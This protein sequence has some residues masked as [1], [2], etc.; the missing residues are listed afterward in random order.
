L[1]PS[2]L[3]P[4]SAAS[5][6]FSVTASPS[7]SA[8]NPASF[9]RASSMIASLL[10]PTVSAKTLLTSPPTAS[11]TTPRAAAPSLRS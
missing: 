3:T 5:A 11:P 2:Q 4:S 6:S 9:F 7:L 10:T 1:A 8:I